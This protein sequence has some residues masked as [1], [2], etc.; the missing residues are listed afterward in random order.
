[1]QIHL[2]CPLVPAR[3]SEVHARHGSEAE[4]VVAACS[5]CWK[6]QGCQRGFPACM[7]A[8]LH[9][10]HALWEVL[11]DENVLPEVFRGRERTP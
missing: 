4:R 9:W 11:R 6:L 1:M 8:S 2:G 5:G 3:C 10:N 7:E